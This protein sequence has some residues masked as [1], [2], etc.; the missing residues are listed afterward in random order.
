M[1]KYLYDYISKIDEIINNK[2]INKDIIDNHLI[3]IGFFQHE[4][5]IHLLVTLFFAAISIVFTVLSLHY[6]NVLMAVVTIILYVMVMFYIKH[7][8][9]LENGVQYLYKLYDKM[10][11]KV[12]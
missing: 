2:K 7:Y 11:K 12:K 5:L 3:K 8:Y 6:L 9:D 10:N 4:R 1:K